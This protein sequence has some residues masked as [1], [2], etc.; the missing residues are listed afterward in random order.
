MAWFKREKAP[1][2]HFVKGHFEIWIVG[3]ALLLPEG[4]LARERKTDRGRAPC[5]YNFVS[6][7]ECLKSFFGERWPN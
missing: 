7:V 5:P 4:C 1:D 6:G 3:A 2:D